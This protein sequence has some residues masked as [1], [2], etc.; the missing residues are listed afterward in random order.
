MLLR[1]VCINGLLGSRDRLKQASAACREALE[2]GGWHAAPCWNR[3]KARPA[4]CACSSS[5]NFSH[6]EVTCMQIR[7]RQYDD[8][9]CGIPGACIMEKSN[10][11]AWA[12][13]RHA[14][15]SSSSRTSACSS[16]Y[17]K[18]CTSSGCL[19]PTRPMATVTASCTSP[20]LICGQAHIAGRS[21]SGGQAHL[22]SIAIRVRT[23]RIAVK[24]S[25]IRR[26]FGD[27][28]QAQE[29][30]I[31]SQ[32]AHVPSQKAVRPRGAAHGRRRAAA[33]A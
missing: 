13:R 8:M 9:E 19:L 6:L 2:G 17:P 24:S 25:T 10:A 27:E 5:V 4:S 33:P 12:W 30:G 7:D 32:P 31:P 26:A 22:P 20:C 18:C 16:W 29:L 21:K 1:H 3:L 28:V 14:V 23:S 11:G 15:P